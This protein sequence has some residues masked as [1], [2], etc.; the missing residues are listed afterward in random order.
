MAVSRFE[1]IDAAYTPFASRLSQFRGLEADDITKLDALP[2]RRRTYEA[3]ASIVRR[4]DQV[5]D[6]IM[7]ISGWAARVRTTSSGMRQIIHILLPGDLLTGDLFLVRRLDHELVAMTKAAVR[8][9]KPEDLQALFSQAPS[10]SMALWWVAEQE[11]GMLR[12][13]VVRLGRRSAL[14]RTC[15][16]LLELHRRL[17]LVQQATDDAFILPITQVEISDALGLSVVHVSRTL[18]KLTQS[19][20]IERRGSVIQLRDREAI[21]DLCDFDLAHFHLDSTLVQSATR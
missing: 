1:S 15:H 9:I 3:G 18:K 2:Y 14:E 13:Q 11:D 12:E 7:M 8:L 20:L 16:L 17:L 10:L 5:H 19:G 4:G 6:V 21:A